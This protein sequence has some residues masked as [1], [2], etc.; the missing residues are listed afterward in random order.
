MQPLN[1]NRHLYHK[2]IKLYNVSVTVLNINF[3]L[4]NINILFSQ[5]IHKLVEYFNVYHA[6]VHLTMIHS[7]YQRCGP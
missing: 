2:H 6:I 1:I 7:K 3:N 5:H 4:L